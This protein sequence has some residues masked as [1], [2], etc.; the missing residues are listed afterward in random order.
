MRPSKKKSLIDQASDYIEAKR[1]QVESAVASATESVRSTALPMLADARDKAG[2]AF[3]DARDKVGPMLAD[4]REKA[5]P[6]LADAREK[7]GPAFAD[8]RAKAAP[9]IAS[10][11]AL[12]AEKAAAGR[13]LANAKVAE[14]K[15]EPAP[16]KGRKLKKI[17]LFAGVA[18]A[19]GLVVK[20]LQGGGA[21]DNWQSS[22]VPAPPPKP[23]AP[24]ASP[25]PPT[26]MAG[27]DEIADEVADDAGGS[28][29]DEAIADQAEAP[30]PVTTPED[31]A[32]VV[33]IDDE[34][35]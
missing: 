18:A 28:S 34:K 3:A 35:K 31:P 1:P 9:I 30:H 10:A 17:A 20:K 24:P 7:A 8:A 32:E 21:S 29:P 13:D 6:Y 27:T 26:H 23:A 14:L 2:P 11:A 4:A 33:A 25:K 16:P 12:A 19:I 22:Y 5:A 15:A